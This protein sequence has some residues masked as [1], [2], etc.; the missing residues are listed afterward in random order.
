MFQYQIEDDVIEDS[1]QPGD[2]ESSRLV[3]RLSLS[4]GGDR[5]WVEIASGVEIVPC[6]PGWNVDASL[7]VVTTAPTRIL[8][9]TQ[10]DRLQAQVSMDARGAAESERVVRVYYNWTIP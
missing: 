5:R 7:H 2:L 4:A 6:G 9:D 10:G 1:V 8:H 3:R